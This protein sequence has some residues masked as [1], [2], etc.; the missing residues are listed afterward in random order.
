MIEAGKMLVGGMLMGHAAGHAIEGAVTQPA[1][2][3]RARE[4]LGAQGIFESSGDAVN[5]AEETVKEVSKIPMDKRTPTEDKRASQAGEV[6]SQNATFQIRYPKLVEEKNAAEGH[7]I[8]RT[9]FDAGEGVGG[10]AL[11]SWGYNRL[12]EMIDPE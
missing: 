1:R 12:G 9:L 5:R 8:T 2:S 3:R 11:G 4:E 6:L 7:S 10:A